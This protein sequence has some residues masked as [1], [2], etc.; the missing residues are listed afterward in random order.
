MYRSCFANSVPKFDNP[1]IK[2]VCRKVFVSLRDQR[3]AFN[4][5]P[6]LPLFKGCNL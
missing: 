4:L 2:D 3:L 1:V 6:R 5:D